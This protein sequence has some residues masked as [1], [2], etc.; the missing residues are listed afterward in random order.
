MPII[1]IRESEEQVDWEGENQTICFEYDKV[2]MPI[3]YLRRVVS[4][5]GVVKSGVQGQK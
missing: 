1:E 3:G 4:Q 5:I 2:E